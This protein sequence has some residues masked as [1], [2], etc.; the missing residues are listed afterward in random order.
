MQLEDFKANLDVLHAAFWPGA[1]HTSSAN[2]GIAEATACAPSPGPSATPS[3]GE[4]DKGASVCEHTRGD[5]FGATAADSGK[6]REGAASAPTAV[7][8]PVQPAA[9]PAAA[10]FGTA[11]GVADADSAAHVAAVGSSD[12]QA[13]V[14]RAAST[15]D[16]GNGSAAAQETAGGV[17]G[18]TVQ[19]ADAPDHAV[20]AD[21]SSRNGSG[22]AHALSTGPP[23]ASAPRAPPSHA[24]G[25][26]SILA[27]VD[28]STAGPS[29]E[30]KQILLQTGATAPLL[31]G[32][33]LDADYI[34]EDFYEPLLACTDASEV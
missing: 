32:A 33:T 11:V 18:A 27:A 15:S 16:G 6:A 30:P 8:S 20:A 29:S 1:Q 9:A 13:H 34:L 21:A 31:L 19:P 3:S 17:S 26:A 24:V 4:N 25:G 12:G 22:T 5:A 28:A 2:K 23:L 10:D 7:P 14:D